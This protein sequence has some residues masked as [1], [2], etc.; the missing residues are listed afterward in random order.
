MKTPNKYV[1]VVFLLAALYGTYEL[2]ISPSKGKTVL[3]PEEAIKSMSAKFRSGDG[4]HAVS[5]LPEVKGNRPQETAHASPAIKSFSGE[6]SYAR[7]GMEKTLR[8]GRDPFLFPRGVEPYNKV[9]EAEKG[10]TPL[11]LKVNAVLI[12]G[13]QKVATLNRAPYVVSIGDWIENEQVLEIEPDHVVLGKNG[14]KR[15]LLL[16]S[17]KFASPAKI[18]TIE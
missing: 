9:E 1:T 15:W 18:R 11:P 6:G 13:R 5:L 16:E 3:K 8:W 7:R 14:G 4:S 12:S 2:V 10:E 17:L